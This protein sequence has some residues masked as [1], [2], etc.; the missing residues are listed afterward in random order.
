MTFIADNQP[1]HFRGEAGQDAKQRGDHGRQR[2][3]PI[4]GAERGN[5]SL[6]VVSISMRGAPSFGS[7]R[8]HATRRVNVRPVRAGLA[9][10]RAR[11]ST[12]NL[13]TQIRNRQ[14]DARVVL[15]NRGTLIRRLR[16][17]LGGSRGRHAA[18]RPLERPRPHTPRDIRSV[19]WVE[20]SFFGSWAFRSPSS[21][22]SRCSGIERR[23]IASKS[24]EVRR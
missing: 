18:R 2:R 21:F 8:P 4:P 16:R 17:E 11:R 23:N 15:A 5:H 20:A 22:Y 12:K 24:R 13:T 7:P 10:S 6:P 14:T 19:S 9:P 1:A 3:R